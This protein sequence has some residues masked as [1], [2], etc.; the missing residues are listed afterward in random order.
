MVPEN[1]TLYDTDHHDLP[2][3]ETTEGEH[4]VALALGRA[5][6]VPDDIHL[7]SPLSTRC[8]VP[9]LS[10]THH[11]VAG[12]R[13]RRKPV[14][15]Q[16]STLLLLYAGSSVTH[17]RATLSRIPRSTKRR[18]RTAP[19]WPAGAAG[20]A[21]RSVVRLPPTPM[22]TQKS[23]TRSRADRRGRDRCLT[24]A[25]SWAAGQ[26]YLHVVVRD[27]Q[28][29]AAWPPTLPERLISGPSG[30][31]SRTSSAARPPATAARRPA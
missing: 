12:S 21:A 30:S 22:S 17:T 10:S 15:T 5:K 3:T 19:S 20:R 18:S 6:F 7:R 16:S 28:Q 11:L 9:I 24:R 8:P 13:G 29:P 4:A 2:D 1:S 23:P 27:Q 26:R 31:S 14:L 25:T